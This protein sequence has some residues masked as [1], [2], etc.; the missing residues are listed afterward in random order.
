M[1]ANL[2]GSLHPQTSSPTF[3]SKR[4]MNDISI[5]AVGAAIIAGL[6]SLLGLIIGKEQKIS[7][8]RQAW[9]NDLRKCLVDYLVQINAIVDVVIASKNKEKLEVSTKLDNYKKL[10]EASHGIKFRVNPQEALAQRLLESMDMFE[11]NAKH[12]SGLTSTKILSL[13]V[14]YTD[15][16]KRLLKSEWDTVKRGEKTYVWTKRVVYICLIIMILL[17]IWLWFTPQHSSS[18]PKSGSATTVVQSNVVIGP[19][20]TTGNCMPPVSKST[21]NHSATHVK[22]STRHATTRISDHPLPISGTCPKQ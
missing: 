7:E 9:I 3:K 16:A 22:Q 10:N 11:E 12:A 20:T 8:F 21:A 19:A 1:L 17:F 6:V 18:L 14:E 13:E 4:T 5:G 2:V 15:S